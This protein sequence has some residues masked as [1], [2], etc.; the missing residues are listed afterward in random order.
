MIQNL[1]KINF[2]QNPE[3]FQQRVFIVNNAIRECL[4]KRIKQVIAHTHIH[5]NGPSRLPPTY[6]QLTV[7]NLI[8]WLLMAMYL[9]SAVGKG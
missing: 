1:S 2:H 6:K 3:N 7:Q 5:Q 9:K 4:G 8:I